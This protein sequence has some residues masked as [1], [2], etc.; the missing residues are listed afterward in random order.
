MLLVLDNCEQVVDTVASVVEELLGR[1]S[2]LR[3]LTTSREALGIGGERLWPLAGLP[4]EEAT[5]LFEARAP[6]TAGDPALASLCVELDGLPL[7]IE[8]AAARTNVLSPAEIVARLG[9][10]FSVLNAGTR[11]AVPRHQTLRALVDWSYELLFDDERRAL[12][13]LSVFRNRFTMDDAEAVCSAVGLER[14]DVVDLVGRLVAK[15][16]VTADRRA[17][18]LLVTIRD[19]AAERLD[20]L[21]LVAA[22]QRAHALHIAGVAAALGPSLLRGDQL[23]AIDVLASRDDDLNAALDWCEAAGEHDAATSLGAALGWYWYV[24]GSWWAARRRLEAVLAHPSRD[25]AARC[26]AL[27]WLGHFALVTDADVDA[28]F[29]AA[30]DQHA[31]GRAADDEVLQA[32]ANVQLC[33]VHLMAGDTPASAGPLEEATRLL[34]GRDE[35]FW[36]GLCH[37]FASVAAFSEGRVDEV[38]QLIAEAVV[39][40]RRSGERWSL[41]NALLHGGTVL[42]LR[43]RLD[44][45]AT[46]FGEALVHV[47][48]LRFRS[49]EARAR[50]RLA[51]VSE[52]LGDIDRAAEL[53]RQ[54][55]EIAGEFGDGTLLNTTRVVLA[56]VARARGQLDEADALTEAV[57][58]SPE[59]RHHELNMVATNERGAVLAAAGR[60]DE[61]LSLHREALRRSASSADLRFAATAL[62]GVAGCLVDT[63]ARRATMLVGAAESVRGR[64][65]PGIG[66]DRAHL[67]RVLARARAALGDA[68]YDATLQAGRGLTA[69]AAIDMALQGETTVIVAT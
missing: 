30:R 46:W 68:R 34:A 61:A 17:L 45:A 21:G 49:A 52:A 31:C 7:A 56:R 13:A 62:E 20:S 60:C 67:D 40:F 29:A 47:G 14:G 44:E 3:V 12:A 41:F 24:R 36:V 18:G 27:G 35:P 57:L 23:A 48:V 55:I 6:A 65:V 59:I 11:T 19:Y 50:V 63:E 69:D 1:T 39:C 25:A 10:R 38:E 37:Y 28:A 15:S 58:R 22:A 9:D 33:R 5:A 64:P 43:G 51:S 42:E 54:C 8:L 32:R 26:I 66:A 16:L 4:R 2:E 53:C